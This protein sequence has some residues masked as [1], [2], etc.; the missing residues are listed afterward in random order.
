MA[1]NLP[2][3]GL[4][5]PERGQAMD[6]LDAGLDG[7]DRFTK[8]DD[9][10]GLAPAIEGAEAVP[11]RAGDVDRRAVALLDAAMPL[12]RL[13]RMHPAA[14][15]ATEPAEPLM[16]PLPVALDRG[17][18]MIAAGIHNGCRGL[19]PDMHGIG[20]DDPL[21]EPRREIT[22]GRDLVRAFGNP[23]LSGHQAGAVLDSCREAP[24]IV[25]PSSARAA[26]PSLPEAAR[27][28]NTASSASG[29][30]PRR[31]FRKEVATGVVKRPRNMAEGADGGQ[32]LPVEPAG[33]LGKG[34]MAATA[35]QAGGDHDGEAEGQAAA[36]PP[37]PAEILHAGKVV[38]QRAQ[39]FG[40]GKGCVLTAFMAW[41]ATSAHGICLASAWSGC[42]K[43]SL[44]WP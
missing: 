19:V 42:T 35:E 30:I 43:T 33:E 9:A 14:V 28:R 39:E 34:G 23:D 29:G 3:S 22:Q 16:H 25:L 26:S 21:A 4:I 15:P 36:L 5:R 40:V 6:G 31:M 32:L 17:Q 11:F 7:P 38:M 12:S 13:F 18:H 41:G 44:A 8:A 24:L 20:S 1:G 27:S 10:E 37:C 2:G